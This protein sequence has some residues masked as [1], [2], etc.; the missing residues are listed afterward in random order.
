MSATIAPDVGLKSAW[1][2]PPPSRIGQDS[3]ALSVRQAGPKAF[4]R[5]RAA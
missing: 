2:L 4:P 5:S 3:G 1:R